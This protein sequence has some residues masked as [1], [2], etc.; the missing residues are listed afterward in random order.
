MPKQ[1]PNIVNSAIR[2]YE[3]VRNKMY[4]VVVNVDGNSPQFLFFFRCTIR[5]HTNAIMKVGDTIVTH[6]HEPWL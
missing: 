5:G 6:P 2:F 4:V 3:I 1:Y